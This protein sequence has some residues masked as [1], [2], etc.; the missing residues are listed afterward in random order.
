MV[1]EVKVQSSNFGAEY[2][3]GGHERQRG[4][5][6]RQRG[7]PRQPLRLQ[8]RLASSPPTT[9]RTAIAG[10]EK[11]KSRFNYSGRQH[12]RSDSLPFPGYNQE[13]TRCSSGSGWRCSARRWTPGSRLSTRSAKRRGPATLSEFLANR[14]QNLNHPRRRADPGLAF[15]A[16]APRRR[17]TTSRRTSRR[18]ASRW[19]ASTRCRTTRDADNR[20]NYVY[21]AAGADQPHRARERESTG[22]S[23]PTR[24][25]TSASRARSEDA[26]GLAAWVRARP[27]LALPTP[28]LGTNRPL[29][30]RAPSS[31]C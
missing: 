10:V 22:T 20:Y 24:R 18:S 8:A 30:T 9:A 6:E 12:R 17:T 21:S 4:H 23:A 29:G 5:E 13:E 11:P 31:R 2:G 16:R 28:S 3:A 1:Q 27:K 26:E 15:P 14:G 25:P 7:V 19:P